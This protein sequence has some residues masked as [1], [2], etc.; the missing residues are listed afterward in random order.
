MRVSLP[1]ALRHMLAACA[2]CTPLQAAE[3]LYV[4]DPACPPCA[5]FERQVGA[6]Y[7]RTDEARRAPLRALAFG[8]PFPADY[9]DI[10]APRVAPTFVLVDEGRELGRFEGYSAE[11]LFWMNLSV[12]MR[13]LDGE[14]R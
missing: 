5:L 13:A 12:L 3:L 8:K 1:R 11:E 10:A 14:T 7:A 2:V 6:V 9:A 4:A